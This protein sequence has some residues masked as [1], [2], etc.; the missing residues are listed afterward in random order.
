MQL[1]FVFINEIGFVIIIPIAAIMYKSKK[2]NPLAGVIAAFAGT[3]FG[4]GTSI[5]VGSIDN[6]MIPYT[7]ISSR[8]VD[9]TFHISLTSNLFIMIVSSVILTL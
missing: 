3:A 4:Y 7:S 1:F 2:R 6:I 8:L 9:P 5:F